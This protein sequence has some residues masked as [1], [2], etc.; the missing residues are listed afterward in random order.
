MCIIDI[1]R[2]TSPPKI[3]R[4]L[5]CLLHFTILPLEVQFSNIAIFKFGKFELR[6]S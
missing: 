5:E 6:Y 3:V 4:F 1:E 2:F